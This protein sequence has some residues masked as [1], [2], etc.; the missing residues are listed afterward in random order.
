MRTCGKTLAMW[1]MSRVRI[2]RIES[3]GVVVLYRRKLWRCSSVTRSQPIKRTSPIK[4]I[5]C[6]CSTLKWSR[7]DGVGIRRIILQILAYT[8][9]ALVAF[10][11]F[12][13]VLFPMTCCNSVSWNGP[14]GMGYNWCLLGCVQRSLLACELR[15]FVCKWTSSA[16]VPRRCPS[17]PC[18]STLSGLLCYRGKCSYVLK[19]GSIVGVWK[20]KRAIPRSR[21][22]AVEV[23]TRFTDL[24]MTQYALLRKD[25]KRSYVDDSAG[26]PPQRLPVTGKC[27][28]AASIC[29]YHPWSL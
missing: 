17:R 15:A 2:F 1:Q 10:V 21:S 26:T 5:K 13:Y 27:K 24:D 11:G 20:G 18:A 8:L 16:P 6:L 19:L 25:T 22:A 9:Y 3:V 28:T 23:K 4:R 12:V 7:Q 29:G 14:H